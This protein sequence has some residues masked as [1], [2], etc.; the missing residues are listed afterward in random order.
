MTL[1]ST[2]PRNFTSSLMRR[3]PKMKPNAARKFQ[4]TSSKCYETLPRNGSE[5]ESR[6][7]G[8]Q[9]D[10]LEYRRRAGIFHRPNSDRMRGPGTGPHFW[11]RSPRRGQRSALHRR[12]AGRLAGESRERIGGRCTRQSRDDTEATGQL[13][14]ALGDLIHVADEIVWR[15][16][17][18][19]FP[20]DRL[21]AILTGPHRIAAICRHHGRR[22]ANACSKG[23]SPLSRTVQIGEVQPVNELHARSYSPAKII[24]QHEF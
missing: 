20:H 7:S 24:V 19:G 6:G 14:G 23:A 22:D 12:D 11:N 5:L 1:G 16:C 9:N 2:T 4:M 13:A 8:E 10:V 17:A 21:H 18:C 3:V 15:H